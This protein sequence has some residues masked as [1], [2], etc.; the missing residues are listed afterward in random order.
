M[1]TRAIVKTPCR[2]MVNGL[3][4]AG[5][6]APDHGLALQ[7]HQAYIK[8]LES[9]DL[10]VTVLPADENFPDSTFV[11]D[12]ALLTPHCA[13]ITR[14]GALSR[15]GETVAIKHAVSQ[16]YEH[17][18]EISGQGRLDA[19]DIMMV[20][21]HYYIGLSDRT[22]PEGAAQMIR[23]LERYGMR[24]TTVDLDHVLHLKTGIA[25]L[26][27]NNLVVCG[28]FI[29]KTEFTSF[30]KI[31]IPEKD[32]YS[33]NCIWVNGK[34]IIPSGFPGTK[35]QISTAGYTVIET[36][37]SEFQKLDGGLSC[38]SLRF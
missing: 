6:G 16:F 10:E 7:Q 35:E 11:E 9:C 18:E 31:I 20:G 25:Y 36:D 29:E 3:T 8:I 21:D 12:G 17:V 22:N 38:L 2:N 15:R 26:E 30:N 19:G 24:G 13:L 33:A 14:P 23:V 34:V 5:L 1:F 32:A 37:M 4:G 28:E 27:N